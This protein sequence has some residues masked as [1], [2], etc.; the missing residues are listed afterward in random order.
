MESNFKKDIN[1]EKEIGRYL[2]SYLYPFIS[3]HFFRMENKNFQKMGID[4]EVE[5]K[6]SKYL[7]DEKCA[8]YYAN[9][10]LQSFTFELS[11]NLSETIKKGW[12]LNTELKTTHYNLIWLNT[13]NPQ[14]STSEITYNQIKNVEV[15]T[16]SKE[17]LKKYLKNLDLE[18]A[19]LEILAKE[20]RRKKVN[21]I[22][23]KNGIELIFSE[24]LNEK[25]INLKINK[26]ILKELA[27]EHYVVS[28]IKIVDKK[29]DSIILQSNLPASSYSYVLHTSP[30]L[31]LKKENE[32]R[33]LIKKGIKV[34]L[35][36]NGEISI[37][38]KELVDS[39]L[40]QIFCNQNQLIYKEMELIDGK[41]EE[42][43]KRLSLYYKDFNI[44]QFLIEHSNTKENFAIKAG[45]GTGKTTV[46]VDRII[47]LM[48]K[49]NIHPSNIV[50]V[51]FTRNSAKVMYE[52]LK[53]A[54]MKKYEVT[55]SLKFLNSAEKLNDMRIQTISS[56]SK[57]LLK[58]LGQLS[59]LGRSFKLRSFKSEKKKW[60]EEILN[61]LIGEYVRES[62][63]SIKQ[64]INPLSFHE[65]IDVVYDFWEEFENNGI[66]S[67]EIYN[68]DFGDSNYSPLTNKLIENMIKRA[69]LKYRNELQKINAIS[70]N[71][72]TREVDEI[73]RV[74]GSEVFKDLQ[75]PIKYL[76]IDEFQDSDN[77]QISLFASIQE[78]F[79]ANIFV[80]GDTNQSIYRFR[81]AQHTAFEIL[82]S[83]LKA[84]GL[85]LN[86]DY[87]LIKNYRS[88][89]NLL[90][91]MQLHFRKWKER[92]WLH[93]NYEDLEG[94]KYSDFPENKLNLKI[95]KVSGKKE[96]LKNDLIPLLKD[97][98]KSIKNLN[99]TSTTSKEKK[100]LAII[101]RTRAEARLI[102][103]WCETEKIH[104]NLKVGGDFYTSQVVK[105]FNE[106]LLFLLYPSE[107]KF[108]L[109]VLAGPFGGENISYGNLD[110]ER[111]YSF[112]LKSALHSI[113][114]ELS[115]YV[116]QL[117]YKPVFSVLRS[118]VEER[119]VL[120]E[121]FS[122]NYRKLKKENCYEEED[123]IKNLAYSETLQYKLN[124]GKLFE[125][126]HQKFSEEFVTL[127][128]IQSWLQVNMA[129]E[130]KEN[131]EIV[132]DTNRL[133]IIT[134][135]GAKGLEYH[136]VI[137]P[138]TERKFESGFSKILFEQKESHNDIK[139]GWKIIKNKSTKFN[140]YYDDM[141]KFENKEVI[142]EEARLLY[143]AMTRAE[144]E[145]YILK[146][147]I[148]DKYHFTWSKLL[149]RW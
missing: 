42:G 9:K 37:F 43:I 109:P 127:L 40:L 23:L 134:A 83:H 13:I 52:K 135:H 35:F 30:E 76:F 60:L 67:E 124:L 137:I 10:N 118:I 36:T 12:F 117:R 59:G 80:V 25:P 47:Y 48:T 38:E 15:M 123:Y 11:Y 18:E 125:I 75:K 102:Y 146:N 126:M 54:L 53:Q 113:G 66:V 99:D 7:I 96:D 145:L 111:G 140:N 72:L 97:R 61:E 131:Q 31:I 65:F 55:G 144:G 90:N 122:R 21:R 149:N 147:E 49:E 24:K 44:E 34:L 138:F 129:V 45:A 56:F 81:G 112:E 73:R 77:S 141:E 51:T 57:G 107:M 87:R 63:K 89:K 128:Q 85:E 27:E 16:V 100:K 104:A 101:T 121:I 132:E 58:E 14:I 82:E 91:E 4:V 115:G 78:A 17:V 93:K 110:I 105:D 142:E 120:N 62:E 79:N 64:I 28:N 39:G 68:A 6:G 119:G 19:K 136:S 1:V 5:S 114:K 46:M 29:S 106:L 92:N 130:R 143:V 2:D 88:S 70:L 41:N 84:R 95:L 50:L 69:V 8:F 98:L 71:D 116:D 26:M 74:F 32:I 94:M 103:Q 22:V 3:S 139:V 86:G 20:Q 108:L 33:K 148:Y 133:D